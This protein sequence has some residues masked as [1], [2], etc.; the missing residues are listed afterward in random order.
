M[1]PR[2]AGRDRI[3]LVV[4]ELGLSGELTKLLAENDRE[5]ALIG[6]C[7]SLASTG[8]R[9]DSKVDVWGVRGEV[10]WESLSS[11][12]LVPL[13][14]G[15]SPLSPDA[16]HGVDIGERARGRRRRRWWKGKGR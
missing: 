16:G 10:K 3:A 7:G 2:D 4:V 12:V 5:E 6:D 15:F 8:R 11:G 13:L 9:G 1:L 14:K